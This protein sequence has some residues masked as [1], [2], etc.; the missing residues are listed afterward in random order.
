[1]KTKKTNISVQ[2]NLGTRVRSNMILGEQSNTYTSGDI[3]DANAVQEKYIETPNTTG[4][5][6]QVLSL[7]AQGKTEWVNQSGGGSGTDI[8]DN[9]IFEED[10]IYQIKDNAIYPVAHP[11]VSTQASILPE[12]FGNLD[13]CEA[14]IVPNREN[15]I[16]NDAMVI[17]AWSFNDRECCPAVVKDVV[18]ILTVVEDTLSKLVFESNVNL[19]Y[20]WLV[21]NL[22]IQILIDIHDHPTNFVIVET[23]NRYV[24]TDLH[25]ITIGEVLLNKNIITINKDYVSQSVAGFTANEVSLRCITNEYNVVPNYTLVKYVKAGGNYYYNYNPVE[26]KYAEFQAVVEQLNTPVSIDDLTTQNIFGTDSLE[27][28]LHV[29][30][31]LGY[32]HTQTFDT[33]LFIS[34]IGSGLE[35]KSTDE[36]VSVNIS[37]FGYS[38]NVVVSNTQYLGTLNIYIK[39]NI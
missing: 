9:I 19:N 32:V 16:P 4:T 14:V 21:N 20:D 39:T 12:R 5:S 8:P 24:L 23:D 26:D 22:E 7:N 3:L 6:G 17:S 11:D 38:G 30:Q 10:G 33:H 31:Y 29:G 37:R 35:L 15:E 13:I 2:N 27:S 25:D 34:G 1:M 36:T 18:P 28:R